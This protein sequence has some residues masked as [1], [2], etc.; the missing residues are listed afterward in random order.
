MKKRF[1]RNDVLFLG[2]VVLLA[3]SVFVFGRF[4]M[5]ESGSLVTVTIDGKVYGTYPL[6]EPQTI[7]IKQ[8]G[9]VTNVLQIKDHKAKMKEAD[10]PDQ[11]CVHQSAISKSKQTIVCLPNKVVAEVQSTQTADYDAIVK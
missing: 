11:L 7:P 3:L 2:I 4:F 6:D 1:G 8:Q 10:C 5:G 9:K